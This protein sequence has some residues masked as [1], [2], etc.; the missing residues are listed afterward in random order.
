LD[1]RPITAC[2]SASG[3][4]GEIEARLRR[5]D[6]EYR[7]FLFRVGPLHDEK[8]KIVRWYGTNT[9]IEDRKRAEEALRASECN[10]RLLIEDIPGLVCLNS[11]QGELEY[12]NQRLVDDTGTS[13]GDLSNLGWTSVL[14]PDDVELVLGT[15]LQSV[16]TGHPHDADFQ[17]RRSDGTYRWFH[18]RTE[19]L[20]DSEDR[21]IRWYGILYDVDDRRKAEDALH[22]TQIELAHITRVMTMGELAAS[23]AHEINQR[24]AANVTNGSAC[25]RWLAGDSPNLDEAREATWRMIRDGNRA[26]DVITRIRALVRKTEQVEATFREVTALIITFI[27]GL[28]DSWTSSAIITAIPIQSKVWSY[29]SKS[30]DDKCDG[31]SALVGPQPIVGG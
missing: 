10:L 6:G 7:W 29:F 26:S 16:A 17:L 11:A 9:D 30:F 13:I 27:P 20:R 24:L 15:W 3:E 2:L 4:T 19:P 18:A 23:I 8:V 1:R 5:F 28:F 14:Y 21:I 31:Y 25:L 22:K 12:V